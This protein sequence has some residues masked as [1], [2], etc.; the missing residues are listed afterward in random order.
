[1]NMVP[2][3][4]VTKRHIPPRR[5]T[6]RR[7]SSHQPM[8]S[9]TRVMIKGR[10][11]L[12]KWIRTMTRE[13]LLLNIIAGTNYDDDEDIALRQ[14]LFCA[15]RERCLD[16]SIRRG[17]GRRLRRHDGIGRRCSPESYRRHRAAAV[18]FHNRRTKQNHFG[19]HRAKEIRT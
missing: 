16:A 6:K 17:I 5:D 19:C 10:E 8:I 9:S 3:E 11:T 2:V 12:L 15:L 7:D 18:G 13:E 4:L 1:V 14:A